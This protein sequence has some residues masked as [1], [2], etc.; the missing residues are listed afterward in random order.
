[1]Q[2]DSGRLTETKGTSAAIRWLRVPGWTWRWGSK[3]CYCGVP[4]LVISLLLCE[5]RL[6]PV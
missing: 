1:M 6:A 3:L 5:K 4:G 2:V